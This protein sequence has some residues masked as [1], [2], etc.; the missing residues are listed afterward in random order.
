MLPAPRGLPRR[1]NMDVPLSCSYIQ[2]FYLSFP[3]LGCCRCKTPPA[4]LLQRL[5]SF[6]RS[7]ARAQP[8]SSD[9]VGKRQNEKRHSIKMGQQRYRATMSSHSSERGSPWALKTLRPN[10]TLLSPHSP[11]TA[12]I[13]A[14]WTKESEIHPHHRTIFPPNFFLANSQRSCTLKTSNSIFAKDRA[15]V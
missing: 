11:N 3:W 10:R 14:N 7:P 5:N 4:T 9:L 1:P 2:R 12:G 8:E 13:Q 6:S 15:V